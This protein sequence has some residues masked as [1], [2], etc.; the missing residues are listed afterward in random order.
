MY[1]PYGTGVIVVVDDSVAK[2]VAEELPLPLYA[3]A[4]D[5]VETSEV[6]DPDI[7]SI[8][9]ALAVV[10]K[11]DGVYEPYGTGVIVVDGLAAELATGE[12]LLLLYA[13][14]ED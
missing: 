12:P 7:G 4:D 6:I 1:E 9:E 8:A 5:A 10:P 2:L 11:P 13:G 14:A 3:G